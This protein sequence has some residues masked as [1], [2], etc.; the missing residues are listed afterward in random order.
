MVAEENG[1]AAVSAKEEFGVRIARAA[2]R[3]GAKPL[4]EEQLAQRSTIVIGSQGRDYDLADILTAI[5]D[6]LGA[7]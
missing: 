2:E 3:L 1:R 7:A 4:T 5:A 6:K